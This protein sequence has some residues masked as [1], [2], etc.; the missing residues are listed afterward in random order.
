MRKHFAAG[1]C[2]A[3]FI[4][5]AAAMAAD[6]AADAAGPSADADIVVTGT[7]QGEAKAIENKRLA[8]NIVEALYAN[9]VGKL[10]DQ[11]VAEAVKRLPGVPAS[12]TP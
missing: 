9:D 6:P 4:L 2:L 3:A 12:A 1:V 11:N 8:D 5:P 10:P 7:R